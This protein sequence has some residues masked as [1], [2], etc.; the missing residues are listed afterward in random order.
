MKNKSFTLIELLVVIVIIG[1]LAGVIMISTSSSINKANFAKAQTFSNAVQEELLFNLLSE[2]TFDE[3]G[4]KDSWGVSDGNPAGTIP[5]Q[6]RNSSS[7]DC[8][9]GGCYSFLGNGYIDCGRDVS[10]NI[11][12][13]SFSLTFWVKSSA[14]IDSRLINRYFPGYNIWSRT[15]NGNLR[16]VTYNGSSDGDVYTTSEPLDGS[17]HFIVFVRNKIN[18]NKLLA[19]V[20]G[21]FESEGGDDTISISDVNKNFYIGAAGTSSQFFEG[22]MDDIRMYNAALS[23]SQI[24]QNYIAG[25]NSMLANGNIS[26]EKYSERIE[27]LG[28]NFLI[29]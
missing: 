22:F 21:N 25:L 12:T 15:T 26:K 2:W 27:S 7:G 14:R 23:S 1:I 6:Y 29:K 4:A 17:W 24:R 19:Y 10:L 20:D 8:V 3:G 5:P 9:I 11:D 18:L 16:F 13:G 28:S